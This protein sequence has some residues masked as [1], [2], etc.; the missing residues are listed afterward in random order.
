MASFLS[1][2]S[3]WKK[4]ILIK[5][6][7]YINLKDSLPP[8]PHSFMGFFHSTDLYWKRHFVSFPLL[9]CELYLCSWH[10]LEDA[11]QTSVLLG[12]C[13]TTEPQPQLHCS[14]YTVSYLFLPLRWLILIVNLMKSKITMETS[15]WAW[16]WVHLDG[17]H[18]SVET[19]SKFVWYYSKD[20][21]SWLMKRRRQ[22]KHKHLWPVSWLQWEASLL[23][24]LSRPPT[25]MEGPPSNC[26]LG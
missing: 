21:G 5:R 14:F 2:F 1:L 15:L 10:S 3:Q 26:K 18:W 6:P 24:L 22:T 16:L 13:P 25:R 20:C 23:F 4:F 7:W 19:T 8:P 9:G 12:K 17:G 11:D